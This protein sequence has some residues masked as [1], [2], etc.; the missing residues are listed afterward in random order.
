MSQTERYPKMENSTAKTKVGILGRVTNLKISTRLYAGFG[1]L[2]VAILVLAV[3]S[4]RGM[5][6][7]EVDFTHSSEISAEALLVSDVQRYLTLMQFQERQ[8]MATSSDADRKAYVQSYNNLQELLVLAKQTV[9]KPER[10]KLIEAAESSLIT[11]N[12]GFGKVTKLVTDRNKLVFGSLNPVGKSLR[13]KI[14]QINKGAFAA[15][16]YESSSF[17]GK[18]QENLLLGRLYVVKFLDTNAQVDVDRAMGEFSSLDQSL[19][20]LGRSLENP[21]RRALLSEVIAEKAK[22]IEAFTA[23]VA[24]IQERNVIREGVLNADADLV[25]QSTEKIRQSAEK[26]ALHL[27]EEVEEDIR[28]METT[29]LFIGGISLAFGL[30][31]AFLISR[32]ITVPLNSLA[33]AMRKLAEGKLETEVCG[34]DRVGAIGAMSKAVQ[35]FKEN[36]IKNKELEA[37]QEQNKSR[38]EEEKRALMNKLADEFDANVG[39]IVENVSAASTELQA[40]AESMTGISENTSRLSATVSTASEEASSNVQ[41]VA[42]AAEEMSHSISEINNQ[43]AQASSAARKAVQE[44]DKTS[45]QMEELASTADSIGEV[46]KLISD[47]AEQTNLLALN[48]TIESARAGEAGRGFAVVASEVKSLASQTSKATETIASQVEEIQRATKAAVQSMGD[49]GKSI[50][51]V[52]ETSTAIA[53]SMEEQGSATQEIAR[54]VQDAASGTEEVSKNIAG[55]NEASQESGAAAGEVTTAAGELSQQAELLKGEVG[56]FIAQVRS[57]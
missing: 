43:V 9:S 45:T 18:A 57:A 21:G 38:A 6:V 7:V 46:V 51:S 3:T 17:A 39:S 47:I 36:A 19:E 2:L 35:V 14:T 49:I 37:E 31:A 16:D 40:T 28:S 5:K 41:T 34:T 1:F 4:F 56:S 27:R 53:S 32:S 54:N 48:A 42:A 8:Y 25:F 29:T 24:V 13:E 22:Y 44:V 20:T 30:L 33:L 10:V 50:R 12:T 26:D 15:G 11:Y 23:L 55:V 52:D